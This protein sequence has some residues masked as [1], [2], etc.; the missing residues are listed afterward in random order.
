MTLK[1][2]VATIAA[3]VFSAGVAWAGQVTPERT[4]PE[5]GYVLSGATLLFPRG[6]SHTATPEALRENYGLIAGSDHTL[7]RTKFVDA[8]NNTYQVGYRIQGS[9]LHFPGEGFHEIKDVAPEIAEALFRDTYGL[10]GERE[11]LVRTKW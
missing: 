5:P 6:G 11:A 2:I 4:S 1:T 9:T 10:I 3:G 7:M 8:Q